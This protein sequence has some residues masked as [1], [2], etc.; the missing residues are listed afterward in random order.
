MRLLYVRMCFVM[1]ISTKHHAEKRG[2]EGGV[3]LT[4]INMHCV[5]HFSSTIDSRKRIIN[6]HILFILQC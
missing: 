3:A 4:W 2:P 5:I 1:P 6:F